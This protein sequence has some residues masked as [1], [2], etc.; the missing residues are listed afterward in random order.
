MRYF[1]LFSLLLALTNCQVEIR[2]KRSDGV[3]VQEAKKD[4][5]YPKEIYTSMHE[6]KAFFEKE[7]VWK[8]IFPLFIRVQIIL[9]QYVYR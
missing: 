2:Q 1:V 8:Q 7:K 6:L 5:D 3:I 4:E 9:S